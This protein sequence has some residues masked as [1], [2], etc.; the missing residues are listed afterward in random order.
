MQ[1]VTNEKSIDEHYSEWPMPKFNNT[2]E[3]IAQSKKKK[4]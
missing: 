3:D 1:N 2:K 4:D